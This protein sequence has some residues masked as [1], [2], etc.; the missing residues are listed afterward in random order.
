[1]AR[2]QHFADLQTGK[3]KGIVAGTREVRV[4]EEDILTIG[5]RTNLGCQIQEKNMCHERRS[6][7]ARTVADHIS[8]TMS[9]RTMSDK[10]S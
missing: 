8:K 9:A 7:S 1:V 4:R 10:N 6:M 5:S 2:D 3:F